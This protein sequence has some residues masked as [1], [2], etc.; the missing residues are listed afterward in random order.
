MV[1]NNLNKTKM[2]L[3]TNNHQG[4]SITGNGYIKVS[5]EVNYLGFN[6]KVKTDISEVSKLPVEKQNEYIQF[7]LDYYGKQVI[8]KKKK[9]LFAKIFHKIFCE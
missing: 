8:V 2:E 4:I 7:C 9:N 6:T 3:L 5:G 1:D